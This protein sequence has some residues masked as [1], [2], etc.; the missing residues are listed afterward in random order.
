M[1]F[2]NQLYTTGTSINTL[3]Y[4]TNKIV[5]V[6]ISRQ[7]DLFSYSLLNKYL[8]QSV[9]QVYTVHYTECYR[10]YKGGLNL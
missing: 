3:Y 6:Y 7:F 9:P 2:I 4:P 5:T 8:R 1:Y 10:W